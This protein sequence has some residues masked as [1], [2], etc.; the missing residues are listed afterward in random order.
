MEIS[1][2][3]SRAKRIVSELIFLRGY[4]MVTKYKR[5]VILYPVH[6]FLWYLFLYHITVHFGVFINYYIR[7]NLHIYI[8]DLFVLKTVKIY[9]Y[10]GRHNVAVWV[11]SIQHLRGYSTFQF[12]TCITSWLNCVSACFPWTRTN[13]SSKTS[14]NP[15]SIYT[16]SPDKA[17]KL[18]FSGYYDMIDKYLIE[19]K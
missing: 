2:Q 1:I 4:P 16:D 15:Q 14:L 5:V 11:L 12:S 13:L 10:S 19:V 7:D 3:K 9:P 18:Q 6:A 17:H 8:S